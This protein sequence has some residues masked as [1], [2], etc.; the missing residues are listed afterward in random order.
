MSARQIKIFGK[1]IFEYRSGASLENPQYSLNDPKLLDALFGDDRSPIQVTQDTALTYSAVW[2]AV[3]LLATTVAALPKNVY[4]KNE[5]GN[6]LKQLSHPVQRLLDKPSYSMNRFIWFERAMYYL[7]LWGDA[8]API[9]RNQYFEPVAMPLVHPKDVTITE[10]NGQLYYKIPG[11]KRLLKSSEVL[12]VAGFG[13]GIRGKDPITVARESLRGG[14]IY[15]DTGNRFFENGYLNDRYISLPGKIPDKILQS[16]LDTWRKMYFSMKNTGNPMVIQGGGD[17]KSVGMP[18]ENMQ[19]LQSK[20]HHVSEVSRWFGVPPHKLF[21][22]ERS[23][24]NNIEHQGIEFV[25]DSALTWTIR[26]ETELYDK[27]ILEEYKTSESIKFNLN[28]LLRGDQQ[29]RAEYYSKATAGRPWMKPDEV[30]ALED[31][32]KLGDDANKLI[33][34][35]NIVGNTTKTE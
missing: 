34:P 30:R 22:L 25:T 13:D 24:N 20:K 12:H 4:R 28:G 26:F 11:Y 23:T 8:I 16:T 21:D 18:P 7:L 2:R 29:S 3:N 15:Q 14:L 6:R 35:A 1:P 32:N 9:H 10:T 5:D 19:F 27:L 31:M 17:M 33:D